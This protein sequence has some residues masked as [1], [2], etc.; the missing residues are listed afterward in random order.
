M[1]VRQLT[2]LD[3]QSLEELQQTKYV[4]ILV[5]ELKNSL[6]QPTKKQAFVCLKSSEMKVKGELFDDC[7]GNHYVGC[8]VLKSIHYSEAGNQ[9]PVF[10]LPN[11][12][13]DYLA[14]Q[15]TP[16]INLLDQKRRNYYAN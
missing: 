13:Q 1:K 8:T 12:I 5:K 10:K 9:I 16:I 2:L 4:V 15:L 7:L 3:E 11:N 14:K 6:V